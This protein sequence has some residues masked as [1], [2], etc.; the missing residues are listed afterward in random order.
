MATSRGNTNG[1]ES[2]CV[3]LS[4][5]GQFGAKETNKM[6]KISVDLTKCM[7]YSWQTVQLL[8]ENEVENAVPLA[9][10]LWAALLVCFSTWVFCP[11]AG[12]VLL[13]TF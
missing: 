6:D 10:L 5:K 3:E 1:D 9:S 2:Q 11:I 7:L 4:E 8:E 12:Q 13:L